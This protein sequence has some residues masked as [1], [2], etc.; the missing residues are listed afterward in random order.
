LGGDYSVWNVL[1]SI[2]GNYT[3]IWYYDGTMWKYYNPEWGN[4]PPPLPWALTEFNDQQN[5]PYWIYMT[6]G[7]RLEIE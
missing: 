1:E 2:S 3:V 5:R 4:N 7:D 6:Q